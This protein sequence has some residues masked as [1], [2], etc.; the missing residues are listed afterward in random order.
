MF[1]MYF[2][3]DIVNEIH[4]KHLSAAVGYLFV[5]YSSLMSGYIYVRNFLVFYVN[6]LKYLLFQITCKRVFHAPEGRNNSLYCQYQ[7][8][9]EK[10]SF[11]SENHTKLVRCKIKAEILNFENMA[12]SMYL[13]T[14]YIKIFDGSL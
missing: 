5:Y 7:S 4:Q 10:L 14:K 6:A 3:H 13:N 12:R 2:I 9:A 1:I 8:C 11:Y